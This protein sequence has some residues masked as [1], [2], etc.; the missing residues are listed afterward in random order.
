M[1]TMHR[2][3]PH[4]A[5]EQLQAIGR[6]LEPI[7]HA[8]IE[9]IAAQD[10]HPHAADL[11]DRALPLLRPTHPLMA[12]PRVHQAH[13]RE[14]LDRVATGA[15]TRPGTAAEGCAVL[16]MTSL[17]APLGIVGAGLYLRLWDL[18]GLPDVQA[19]DH[20]RYHETTAGSLIDEAESDLRRRL[21]QPWRRLTA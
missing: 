6:L 5:L 14:L 21:R 7:G 20:G 12:T 19:A 11:L 13:C 1:T 2:T 3:E 4:P 18:A 8:A 9:I 16:C 15:D 17:R 10:R